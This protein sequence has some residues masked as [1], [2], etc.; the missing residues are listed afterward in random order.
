MGT[1]EKAPSLFARV[2]GNGGS[3]KNTLFWGEGLKRNL[4]SHIL[5][6]F[7]GCLFLFCSSF[8]PVQRRKQANRVGFRV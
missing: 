5:A 3:L 4:T 2:V 1:G 8:S 7:L 6:L